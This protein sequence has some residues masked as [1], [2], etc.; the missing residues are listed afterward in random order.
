MKIT[1]KSY[2][3]KLEEKQIAKKKRRMND[4]YTDELKVRNIFD[5]QMLVPNQF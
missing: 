2:A 1:K 4:E 3:Q 5:S